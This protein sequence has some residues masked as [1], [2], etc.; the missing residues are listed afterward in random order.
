MTKRYFLFAKRKGLSLRSAGHRAGWLA[1]AGWFCRSRLA[2]QR[3]ILNLST[4]IP[5]LHIK[6]FKIKNT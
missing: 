1:A 3:L 6:N 5:K 4:V 2:E